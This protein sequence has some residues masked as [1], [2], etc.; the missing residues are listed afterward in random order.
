MSLTVEGGT[1]VS[2]ALLLEIVE[3]ELNC[4]GIKTTFENSFETQYVRDIIVGDPKEMLLNAGHEITL[5]SLSTNERNVLNNVIKFYKNLSPVTD[6]SH[7][8]DWNLA[9]SKVYSELSKILQP[10]LTP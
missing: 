10:A 7:K 8:D 5:K 6:E 2:R 4:S 9:I 1:R 3:K